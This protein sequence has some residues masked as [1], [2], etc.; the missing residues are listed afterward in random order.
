MK[1]YILLLMVF[2]LCYAGSCEKN[3]SRGSRIFIN[4]N[5]TDTVRFLLSDRYPD[6]SLPA[7]VNNSIL[8]FVY[9]QSMTPYDFYDWKLDDYFNQ[10]PQDTLSVFVFSPDT[11]RKYSWEDIR[12]SYNVLKRYDLSIADLRILKLRVPYLPT[13]EMGGMKMYPH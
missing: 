7:M 9:P 12:I 3:L 8:R 4:N 2:L 6:T 10:L 1:N 5:T 11:L 13:N